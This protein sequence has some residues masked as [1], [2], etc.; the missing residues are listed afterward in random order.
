MRSVRLSEQE[1]RLQAAFQLTFPTGNS[2]FPVEMECSIRHAWSA[3]TELFIN[4]QTIILLVV[5]NTKMKQSSLTF[6]DTGLLGNSQQ[7][8]WELGYFMNTF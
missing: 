6:E 4:Q 5:L 1:I 2:N 8:I 7:F 3:N